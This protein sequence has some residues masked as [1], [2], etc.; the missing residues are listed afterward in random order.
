M[1]RGSDG[2]LARQLLRREGYTL[3]EHVAYA[4]LVYLMDDRRKELM[5]ISFDAVTEDDTSDAQAAATEERH[6][7]KIK[8]TLSILP[9]E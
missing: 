8:A 9:N 3:P 2:A 1:R 5:I 4:R 6:L 7:Q